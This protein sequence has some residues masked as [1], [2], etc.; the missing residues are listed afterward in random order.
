MNES[1]EN[2]G[3]RRG[4]GGGAVYLDYNAS[5]PLWPEARE[6]VA[7]ALEEAGNPSSVHRFGRLARRRLDTAREQVAA[8]VGA[9]PDEIVFTSGGTEANALALA[10]R[11]RVLVSAVEHDSVLA[12]TPEAA[13]IPVARSGLVDPEALRDLL[14]RTGAPA[15]V[16]VMLAN[17]ETGAIQPLADIVAVAREAGALVHTDAVQAVGR[18]PVDFR[19]LGVDLMTVSAHKLGG[20]KGAG[21][22][23]VADG[24]PL[25]AQLRGGGQEMGRRAGTEALPAIAGFGAAAEAVAGALDRFAALSRLRDETERRIRALAPDSEIFAA[26]APRLPNTTC[27][28]MPGV[29]AETQVMALDLAGVAVSAGAACSSGKVRPSHVLTAMG[30]TAGAAASAIRVS[31]GW[32]STDSDVERLL[33][34]WGA[35][36][37]RAGGRARTP[38]A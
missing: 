38:A 19:A 18:I 23:V 32:D 31:F 35:L 17:N 37:A 9:R 36:Y 34:A 1:S 13:R 14:A 21:A 5:A 8:L 15:L 11:D 27:F 28:T 33:Q 16:S 4:A 6:A 29:P 7:A 3:S 26:G 22:L 12:A 20:P 10:G 24:I 30:A 25:A 2:A